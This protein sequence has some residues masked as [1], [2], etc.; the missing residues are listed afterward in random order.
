VGIGFRYLQNLVVVGCRLGDLFGNV[1]WVKGRR[2]GLI[3]NYG[4]YQFIDIIYEQ[5]SVSEKQMKK[6]K[7]PETLQIN[8]KNRVL[9]IYILPAL[10][11][12]IAAGS[13]LL[14]S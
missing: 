6:M 2:E 1:W 4:A 11:P 8:G 12:L 5:Q 14:F 10:S 9:V 13:W 7:H 3:T